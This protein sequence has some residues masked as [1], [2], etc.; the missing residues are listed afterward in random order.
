MKDILKPKGTFM[1]FPQTQ[2]ILERRDI[3]YYSRLS[4]QKLIETE[5]TYTCWIVEPRKIS[6]NPFWVNKK[7]HFYLTPKTTGG[8]LSKAYED[9]PYTYQSLG[10]IAIQEIAVSPVLDYGSFDVV[11]VTEEEII[12]LVT[13]EFRQFKQ[14]S[15]IYYTRYLDGLQFAILLS[16]Q[17]YD[18]QLMENLLNVEQRLR[19]K[20]KDKQIMPFD[21]DYLFNAEVFNL[22]ML[23]KETQLIYG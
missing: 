16:P 11:V 5:E 21:I 2:E 3:S 12:R 22:K 13:E 6:D 10:T 8:L 19:T 23:G 7:V 15:H 1:D 9:L 14:T 18:N 4:S 20:I 17:T